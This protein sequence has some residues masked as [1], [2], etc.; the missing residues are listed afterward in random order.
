MMETVKLVFHG[1]D[2]DLGLSMSVVIITKLRYLVEE[3]L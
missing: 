1:I 2:S 3:I